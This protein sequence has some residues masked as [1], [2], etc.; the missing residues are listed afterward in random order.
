[1]AEKEMYDY[2]STVTPDY[3][4]TTLNVSCQTELLETGE[5][6]QEIHEGDDTSEEVI[7]FSSTPKFF[8]EVQWPWKSASDTGTILD[9]FT[10]TAKGYGYSR[11]FKWVH[12][13]DG[14]T[15][16]VKFRSK[17]QRIYRPGVVSTYGIGSMILKVIGRIVDP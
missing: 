8:I 3:S 2:L 11:S 4:A 5:F 14:H 15:Y 6:S 17:I 13:K 9:F 7:S 16:V 12:P 10:D 1:M